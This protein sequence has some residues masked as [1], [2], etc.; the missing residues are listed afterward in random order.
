MFSNKAFVNS[1]D[2]GLWGDGVREMDWAVGQVLSTLKSSGVDNNTLVFFTSD[3]GPHIELCLE[4]GNAGPFRGGKAYSSWEG[5]TY[6][7]LYLYTRP[8]RL[9]HVHSVSD[10]CCSPCS[11]SGLR[12]PG[13]V[14]WR[15]KVKAGVVT[16]ELATTMVE[17]TFI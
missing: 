5:G 12:V 9:L 15:G 8:S 2:N 4:G 11:K 3:H 6:I 1:S 10:P 16:D 17:M 7:Y 14:R 13:I